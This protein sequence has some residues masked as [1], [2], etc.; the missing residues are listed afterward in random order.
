LKP[1]PRRTDVGRFRVAGFRYYRGPE[2]IDRMRPGEPIRLVAEPGNPH[3]PLAVRV[4]YAGEKL[5]Y[6][7]RRENPVLSR[8]LRDGARVEGRVVEV[9]PEEEPWK[10]LAVEAL[11]HWS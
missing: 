10:M 1:E 9:R 5:G 6:V 11:L 8:L 2:L 4:E 3:D 7:P